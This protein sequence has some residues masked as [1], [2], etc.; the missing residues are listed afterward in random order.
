MHLLQLL[1]QVADINRRVFPYA[2]LV[3]KVLERDDER[4]YSIS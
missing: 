1:I 3:N 2:L 4:A